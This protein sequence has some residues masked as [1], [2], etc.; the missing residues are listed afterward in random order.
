MV[1]KQSYDER[2]NKQY[3]KMFESLE[4]AYNINDELDSKIK[5]MEASM[6]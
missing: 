3:K 6:S 4:V 5:N 1:E 2:V